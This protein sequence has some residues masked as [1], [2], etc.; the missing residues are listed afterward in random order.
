MDIDERELENEITEELHE[1]Y[2]TVQAA[3]I[4]G[5]AR[6]TLISWVD[7][8]SEFTNYMTNENNYKLFT[9][10]DIKTF[11]AIKQFRDNNIPLDIIISKVKSS[12]L[13]TALDVVKEHNELLNII[14]QQNQAISTLQQQLEKLEERI[15]DK[16]IAK[17]E[18]QRS[19]ENQK[20]L[21][22]LDEIREQNREHFEQH[23]KKK[24]FRL[25]RKG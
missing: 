1:V 15:T 17:L 11:K 2:N 12:S 9:A 23:T 3:K 5:V 4:V 10:D 6:T 21:D 18:L 19:I 7:K 22:K 14:Q 16:V 8:L 24:K 25:F 20:L 13:E